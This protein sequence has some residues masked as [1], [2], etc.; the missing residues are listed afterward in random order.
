M[1]AHKG[2]RHHKAKLNDGLVRRMRLWHAEGVTLDQIAER[3]LLLD[4]SVDVS[5]SGTVYPAVARKTWKHV[6]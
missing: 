6:T 1:P 2:A 3:L 4:P 5:V